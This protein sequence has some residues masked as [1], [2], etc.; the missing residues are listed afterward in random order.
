[1]PTSQPAEYFKLST[2]PQPSALR[3]RHELPNGAASVLMRADS[4][5]CALHGGPPHKTRNER[6]VGLE[7]SLADLLAA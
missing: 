3:S 6:R 1:M 7:R 5:K 4:G 2:E